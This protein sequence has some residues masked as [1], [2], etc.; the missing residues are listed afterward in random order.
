MV[1]CM[2]TDYTVVG[3]SSPRCACHLVTPGAH[4]VRVS[5]GAD[6][7]V[8]PF[9]ESPSKPLAPSAGA[10]GNG[11]LLSAS[12]SGHESAGHSDCSGDNRLVLRFSVLETDY[13]GDLNMLLLCMHSA[14]GLQPP[15]TLPSTKQRAGCL[16]S[17]GEGIGAIDA[18]HA[19]IKKRRVV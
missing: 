18:Q 2:Y 12:R 16:L 11:W 5:M 6:S 17:D 15:A 10:K 8:F 1:W 13:L 14:G 9:P 3:P 7:L 19:P 4:L